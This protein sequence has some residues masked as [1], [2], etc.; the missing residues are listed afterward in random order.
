MH[1]KMS[2]GELPQEKGRCYQDECL[3]VVETGTG[4]KENV[5]T[6]GGKEMRKPSQEMK[7]C[8][9]CG[10]RCFADM[11]TCFNCLHLFSRDAETV[12]E[13]KEDR[14]HREGEAAGLCDSS[15]ESDSSL[16]GENSFFDEQMNSSASKRGGLDSLDLPSMPMLE[17]DKHGSPSKDKVPAFFTGADKAIEIVVNI[18]LPKDACLSDGV[19]S[20]VVRVEAR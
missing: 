19:V 16:R 17:E 18:S 4:F 3:R 12:E 20:P 2:F 7:V 10:A 13:A 11:D 15:A 6:M 8:P 5:A 14:R 1:Q 9:V